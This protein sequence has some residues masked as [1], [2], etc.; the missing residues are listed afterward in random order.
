[1]AITY[2]TLRRRIPWI[3]LI[4]GFAGFTIM[5]PVK[6]NFRKMVWV[7]GATNKDQS[8]SEKIEAMELAFSNGMT[9]AEQM[10]PE[11]IISI[12]TERLAQIVLF[13][14]I[15]EY[16]PHSVPYWKGESYSPLLWKLVPTAVYPTKANEVWGQIF[17][18]RYNLLNPRDYTTSI[19]LP[20]LVEFYANFGPIGVLVGSLL[21]GAFY[22]AIHDMFVH[23]DLGL[24]GLVA[25][26]F[27]MTNFLEFESNFSLIVGFLYEQLLSVA[28][29]YWSVIIFRRMILG[30]KRAR[31]A[32]P[33]YV[34][35]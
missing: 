33:A 4:V 9:L 25:V 18:H 32:R 30:V 12:A 23:R 11:K 1:L 17:G 8:E 22:R 24:G 27:I 3:F 14:Q 21:L 7:E 6:A 31:S 5:Q 29:M 15:V 35:G 28:V 16:T 13:A 19:N 10:G 34:A 20:Q 26:L 2:A